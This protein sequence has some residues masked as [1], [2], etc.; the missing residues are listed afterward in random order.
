MIF[1]ISPCSK[2]FTYSPVARA[3]ASAV[4]RTSAK[5]SFFNAAFTCP[6]LL[7]GNKPMYAEES[8]RT[9]GA[10]PFKN[11]FTLESSPD[12]RFADC[13]QLSRHWPHKIQRFGMIYACP[14]RIMM[15]F[16][17]QPRTHL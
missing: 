11:A 2:S 1:S 7:Y 4:S 5:P 12:T 17:S 15:D 13:G 10:P 14:F 16:T 6:L 8:E 3:A 9:T